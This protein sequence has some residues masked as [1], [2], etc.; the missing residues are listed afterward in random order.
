MAL[1]RLFQVVSLLTNITHLCTG[2][3]GN[4]VVNQASGHLRDNRDLVGFGIK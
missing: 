2:H 1:S 3:P 4:N